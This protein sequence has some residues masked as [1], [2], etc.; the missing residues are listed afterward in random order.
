MKVET[1][2]FPKSSFLAIDKDIEILV[3]LFLKNDRLKKLLYY[4][5]PKALE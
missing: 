5:V 2:S 3:N 1:Y 4:D